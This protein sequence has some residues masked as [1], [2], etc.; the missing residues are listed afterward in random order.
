MDARYLALALVAGL[1][2]SAT[3]SEALPPL[4]ADTAIPI[5][6]R[7]RVNTRIG[8]DIRNDGQGVL[9]VT[10]EAGHSPDWEAGRYVAIRLSPGPLLG[11]PFDVTPVRPHPEQ[12]RFAG[13]A[14]AADGRFA[15]VETLGRQ[16]ARR[17]LQMQI[18]SQDD[19]PL[20]PPV[21]ISAFYPEPADGQRRV[22][23][24][25]E[26]SATPEAH[27][28]T[29]WSVVH[30]FQTV[31]LGLASPRLESRRVLTQAVDS[32]GALLGTAQLIALRPNVW[33]GATEEGPRLA[34]T[35]TDL[36]SAWP[37]AYPQRH[38]ALIQPLDAF[39][40]PVGRTERIDTLQSG[41][42]MHLQV[43]HRDGRT[44]LA[45]YE[46]SYPAQTGLRVR[47]LGADHRP[48]SPVLHPDLPLELSNIRVHDVVVSASGAA[49][50]A[51]TA[52]IRA[53][54]HSMST[55][56]VLYCL[57]PSGELAC[58]ATTLE[59]TGYVAQA[60]LR[61]QGD[62]LILAYADQGDWTQDT[63]MGWLRLI[64]LPSQLLSTSTAD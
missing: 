40:A 47:F 25:A 8:L 36:I 33:H 10:T 44:A 26:I 7:I 3:R 19:A 53:A 38:A 39:G 17:A 64:R 29:S 22:M 51:L 11:E 45:W 55:G 28:L 21:L 49:I 6:D 59:T 50:V 4:S 46:P 48:A 24:D 56:V 35:G 37:M 23:A 32:N 30:R 9:L 58:A 61:P 15:L 5:V 27:W 63:G 12:F 16:S 54:D 52:S 1:T 60:R 41:N 42:A 31:N 2:M 14:L 20:P 34:R 57:E 62:D 43:D 18:V 13:V